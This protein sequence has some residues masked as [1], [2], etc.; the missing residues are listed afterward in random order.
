MLSLVLDI[1]IVNVIHKTVLFKEAEEIKNI[2]FLKKGEIE[3]F[4]RV[5]VDKSKIKINSLNKSESNK[6][7]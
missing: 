2:Y 3:L 5:E 7:K 6:V 1:E 4:K